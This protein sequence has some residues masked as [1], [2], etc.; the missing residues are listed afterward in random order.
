MPR[1]QRKWID[2]VC[3]HITH[4]CHDRKFLFRYKKYRQFY[5]LHLYEMVKRYKID[6]L[7]YVVT[8]NHV[9][10]LLSARRADRISEGMRYLHGR[11]AQ[12]YNFQTKRQGSFWS[13]RFH[14]TMIEDGN[15]LASC[16]FYI[17][18]N[19][20]RAGAV[21]HP[22]KWDVCG[23]HEFYNPRTRYRVVNTERL[24][25]AV[26]FESIEKFRKWHKLIMEEKLQEENF[27]REVFW[28]KAIAVGNKEWVQNK[29]NSLNMKRVDMQNIN[30]LFF[31]MG[32]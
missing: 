4:R 31:A 30:D 12:W 28:S 23:Y 20:V 2:E 6:V 10:L 1:R 18:L 27:K 24:L 26:K 3:Y 15:H 14:A 11:V 19:M 5:R 8:S 9:H 21:K 32:K 16:I 7:D 17:D 13:D 25:S 29:I 22:S